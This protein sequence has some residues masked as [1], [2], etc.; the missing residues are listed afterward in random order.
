ML[1]KI[2]RYLTPTR[3]KAIYGIVTAAVAGALA[4]GL[5]TTDQLNS[6][7]QAVLGIVAAL[8]TLMAA[9]NTSAGPHDNQ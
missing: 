5:V 3:R 8:T 9:L 2:N 6:A 4:F 7:V 1:A